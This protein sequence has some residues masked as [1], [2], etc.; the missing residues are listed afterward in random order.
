MTGRPSVSNPEGV[1]R[2]LDGHPKARMSVRH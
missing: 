1:V 2:E